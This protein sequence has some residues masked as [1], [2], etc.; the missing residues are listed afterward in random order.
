MPR[1]L[2]LMAV[3]RHTAASRSTSPLMREQQG[4]L[5]GFP[6]FTFSRWSKSAQT[7]SFRVSF[8]QDAG[9]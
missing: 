7:P 6:I 8:G 5:G 2:A 9:G 1:M 3:Q 4:Y